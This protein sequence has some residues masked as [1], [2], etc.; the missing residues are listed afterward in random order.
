MRTGAS[1]MRMVSVTVPILWR[2]RVA[3]FSL[4]TSTRQGTG[5]ADLRLHVVSRE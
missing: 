3:S 4:S 2:Y 5:A 1:V